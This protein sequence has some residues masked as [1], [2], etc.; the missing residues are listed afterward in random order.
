M[1][2]ALISITPVVLAQ[3]AAAFSLPLPQTAFAR[4]ALRPRSPPL[5]MTR[6]SQECEDLL[7]LQVT[8]EMGASQLYLSAS[9]WCEERNL[10]GMA[11]YMLKESEEERQHGLKIL[12][13][14]LKRDVRVRLQQLVAP[15]A[16][17]NSTLDVWNDLL[18]AEKANTQS[19]FKLADAA[20]DCRDHA[21]LSF[22]IPYHQEQVDS[23]GHLEVI[24]SKVEDESL[25]PGLIRQLDTELGELAKSGL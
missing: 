13:F 6:V 24:I 15:Q 17:W 2:A 21:L 9:I 20:Q 18:D 22:L 5:S 4:G 8:R 10:V 14:A 23:E 16:D 25:T 1:K 3:C 11:S 19:L 7:N 12:D